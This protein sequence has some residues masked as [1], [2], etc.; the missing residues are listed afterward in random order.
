M[1][2]NKKLPHQLKLWLFA[3]KINLANTVTYI[4]TG[5]LAF[6]LGFLSISLTVHASTLPKNLMVT[7]FIIKNQSTDALRI[8]AEQYNFLSTYSPVLG[9]FNPIKIPFKVFSNQS[10]QLET[11]QFAFHCKSEAES[12]WADKQNTL[13]IY[14]DKTPVPLPFEQTNR[15]VRLSLPDISYSKPAVGGDNVSENPFS[16]EGWDA[17]YREHQ[18]DIVQTNFPQ[19]EEEQRCLGQIGVIAT[20]VI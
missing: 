20:T 7:A 1:M 3:R 18:F 9:A 2:K 17:W 11:A 16:N 14:F 13:D 19:R 5:K 4:G 6:Y 15:T 8:E 12:D 10:Y